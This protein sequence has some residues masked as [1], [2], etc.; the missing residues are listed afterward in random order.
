MTQFLSLIWY[1][2]KEA[3]E[4]EEGW[5]KWEGWETFPF[6]DPVPEHVCNII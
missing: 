1:K 4:R 3:E 6:L 5:Q 2:M